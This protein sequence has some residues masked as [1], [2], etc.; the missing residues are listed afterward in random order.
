MILIHNMSNG[1]HTFLKRVVGEKFFFIPNKTGLMGEYFLASKIFGKDYPLGDMNLSTLNN[2][3]IRL[4]KEF[5]FSDINMHQANDVNL[6]INQIQANCL[7]YALKFF[8]LKGS[9]GV[10]FYIDQ[11][12]KA[13]CNKK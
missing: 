1:L 7:Y 6:I 2:Y 12:E 5:K 11:F 9:H 8:L 4:E 13:I 3:T 10:K